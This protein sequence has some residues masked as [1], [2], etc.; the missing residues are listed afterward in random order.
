[1]VMQLRTTVEANKLL[2]QPDKQS[3]LGLKQST[4]TLSFALRGN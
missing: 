2:F 3:N 4:E 1:M